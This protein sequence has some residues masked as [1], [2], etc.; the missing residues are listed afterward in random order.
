MKFR[1]QF[2]LLTLLIFVAAVAVLSWVYCGW[3]KWRAYWEEA[4]FEFAVKQLKVG[5][6]PAVAGN[7]LSIEG[8]PAMQT[9]Y[10]QHPS[11]RLGDPAFYHVLKQYS[12]QNVVYLVYFRCPMGQSAFG[13]SSPCSSIE[14]FRFPRTP[15]DG[16]LLSKIASPSENPVEAYWIKAMGFVV[17]DRKNNPG[18]DC[19]LIYA[20]PPAKPGDS[21]D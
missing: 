18:F 11:A 13:D 16:Q 5:I 12:V 20:D 4:R 6:I 7:R 10:N 3:P 2:S 8:V 1:P 21:Y 15:I 14:V 19:Q 9:T 17:G